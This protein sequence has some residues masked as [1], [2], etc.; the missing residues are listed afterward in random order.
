LNLDPEQVRAART[1][2]RTAPLPERL[3]G[4][5]RLAEAMTRTPETLSPALV[6]ELHAA[7]L[8]VVAIE[9]AANIVFHFNFINRL[10]DAFDFPRPTE[11]QLRRM[12]AL[13][14]RMGGLLGGKRP[15][16]SWTRGLDGAPRPVEVEFGRA[17]MFEVPGATAPELRRAVES[18]TASARGGARPPVEVPGFLVRYLRKL[19]TAAHTLADEDVRVLREAGLGDD[20]IFEL[21]WVGAFGAAVAPLERLFQVLHA[22]PGPRA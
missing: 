16:P 13:L 12:A 15:A 6:A 22:S 19:A 20:A 17:R 5:L 4:A 14:N 3:R 11:R 8:D 2:F 18:L 7:G 1:D 21:T 10:A 9:E